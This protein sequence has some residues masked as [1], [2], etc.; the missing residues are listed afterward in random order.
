M[1]HTGMWEVSGLYIKTLINVTS[2]CAGFSQ[3]RPFLQSVILWSYSH[4]MLYSLRYLCCHSVNYKVQ[5]QLCF[6]TLGLVFVG[7]TGVY[8][9]DFV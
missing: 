2:V 8:R 7:E 6:D 5:N 4:L 3:Q 9:Q 1:V